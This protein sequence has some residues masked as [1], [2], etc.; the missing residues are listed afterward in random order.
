MVDAA[1]LAR[2][3]NRALAR[4]GDFA[5]VFCE[6][7]STLSYRLQEG[8]IHEASFGVTL[9]VGIRV[10]VGESAGYACSDDVREDALMRAADAA[11]LVAHDTPAR[12]VA[13]AELQPQAIGSLYAGE[14][15]EEDPARYV[16]LLERADIAARRYDPS[17][18]AVNA[19]VSDELQEVWIASSDGKV[20]L[21]RRPLVTLGIQVVASDKRERGSGYAGDGGRT[22]LR[23]F[24]EHTPETLASDAARIATVNL[25]ASPA[26]AGEMEMIVGAGGGG[27]LLHEAVGHG[28][29]SDFNRRG[30]SLYSGRVGERVA[31]R[32]VTIYDDG[33]LSEERG[34]LNVDDEGIAGQHNVLVHEGVLQGYMQDRLNARLMGT[35]S[36][37]SG[38]RQSFRFAPQPRMCNTYMPSGD[39]S[40]E[41]IIASTRRGL[42]AKSFA[43]GQVEI[44]KGDFVFMV[45]EG[46]LVEDGKVTVPVRNATIVGNGP[47]IMMKVV[48]VG[49]DS[50]LARRH[51]TCGKGGQ[52]VPVGV[53]MP[54]V[55]IS[56]IT[57]GGTQHG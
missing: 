38:R 46:Y 17:V 1:F 44:S 23:Y 36:T 15:A 5:D 16:A 4:G 20:V 45:G 8:Q 28:L 10:V 24:D 32:L 37:G 25:R 7:R 27:V 14:H 3:L 21:D 52:Y 29:E 56:S 51:Y 26:P 48:A 18:V 57:V 19:Q 54:T 2:L 30:T 13:V 50:R 41:D 35:A 34:S 6:R 55:K 12:V 11:S 9:G 42:Y 39:S 53:G 22:S 33:N 49:N 31:S 40:V 47:E 43:G